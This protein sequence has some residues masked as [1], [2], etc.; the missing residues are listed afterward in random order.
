MSAADK[1]AEANGPER[2]WAHGNCMGRLGRPLLPG[3]SSHWA[4]WETRTGDPNHATEYV[5]ADLADAQ[6]QEIERLRYVLEGVRGAID[7]GRNEPLMIWRDQINI[8]LGDAP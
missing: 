8:A 3:V 2:I 6:A 7:T 4:T 1:I 5:R